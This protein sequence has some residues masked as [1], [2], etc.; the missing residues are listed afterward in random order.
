MMGDQPR[1]KAIVIG[2]GFGGAV[3]ACRLAQAGFEVDLLERGRRYGLA[4]FP[5][6]PRDG[7]VL[8]E[9]RRWTWG[10]SY[11]LWDVRNLEGLTVVQTAGY[12]GGSLGYANVHL[13]AP[14]DV[15]QEGW[16]DDCRGT[17][18]SLLPPMPPKEYAPKRG[19]DEF[20]DLVGYTLDVKP[21]P[22]EW[23]KGGKTLAM[24]NAFR[25]ATNGT[26]QNVFHPPLAIRYP[27]KPERTCG[28]PPTPTP[29]HKLD[30]N[31]HGKPQGACVQCGGCCFGCRY[32][33]KN[34]L[35][36]NYLAK[37]EQSDKVQVRTL[38]EVRTISRLADGR[39]KVHYI[40]H[41]TE[42]AG[43]LEAPYVF[44]CAGSV[45]S[46]ELLL[47]SINEKGLSF[48]QPRPHSDDPYPGRNYFFNADAPAMVF[49]AAT[50]T[51]PT[52]GPVISTALI[53]E[54]RDC[55][56]RANPTAPGRHWFLIEDGGYPASAENLFSLFQTPLLLERNRF[57]PSRR[58]HAP[59]TASPFLQ[60]STRPD[61][62]PAFLAGMMA[63]LR[64]E[65]LPNVL[66]PGFERAARV[67][68]RLGGRLRDGELIQLTGAVLDAMVLQSGIFRAL[69]RLRVDR[70]AR[71]FWKL[72][73]RVAVAIGGMRGDRLLKTTRRIT[74]HR[75]GVDQPKTFPTR[76]G[77][78][79]MGEPYPVNPPDDPFDRR[80][81]VPPPPPGSKALLLAMGRDDLPA[82][83][84]FVGD[85]IVAKFDDAGFPTLTEEERLMRGIADSLQGTLRASPL[86][87]LARRPLSAHSHGG[88]TLG[89]VT[90]DWGEV[91]HNKNLF[92]NDG[93]LL[94]R[95][96]GVNPSA[97]IAALAERNIEHFVRDKLGLAPAAPVPWQREKV[98]AAKWAADRLDERV[99]LMPPKADRI[100]PK[101]GP[102]GFSFREVMKGH[103]SPIDPA[104][105][106]S[107]RSFLPADPKLRVP[108]ARFLN[109]EQAGRDGPRAEFDL[110]ARVLDIGSFLNDRH[111]AMRVTGELKLRLPPDGQLQTVKI[112][113]GIV[114]LF[115][116]AGPDRRLMRYTLPFEHPNGRRWTLTGVKEIEDDRGFDAWLD[117]AVLYTEL[118]DDKDQP[119]ARGV[120]R[121]GIR[122]FLHNQF[123]GLRSE[124]T[125]DPARVI[126][127]LGS[128]AVFFF[129]DLQ[130]IYAPE[131]ERFRGLFGSGWRALPA[132]A[133][134]ATP[135][136]SQLLR[137]L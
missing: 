53:Y 124:G 18:L 72:S 128:F 17:S 32:G 117:T 27:A 41:L 73:Y 84:E 13:R 47:R 3:T 23:R 122:D 1:F 126:W 76:V 10:G 79:L 68:L 40:D 130:G 64:E 35:D 61:R 50:K 14:S 93:A 16:P 119:V 125:R 106:A 12:G 78:A 110:R 29:E 48:P 70:W 116:D 52:A 38:I 43:E 60:T 65:A 109:P 129:G 42:T 85:G 19:L 71:W 100:D 36:R 111:H 82:T 63:A 114:N 62:Y 120:L 28:P 103:L 133:K 121:L 99:D 105:G 80:R 44:L 94:P 51:S 11:G 87:T 22:D 15:F 59:L 69:K 97:T 107:T 54:N 33:A 67:L 34:T 49:D 131:I 6:M 66:P 123:K 77:R 92:V 37:A 30:V 24:A 101:H 39:Y 58:A 7:E 104:D 2:T 8:P 102:I 56:R 86:W 137:G 113:A 90:D 134:H 115:T 31:D 75:Y 98:A 95:P 55:A 21:V 136:T 83:L 91:R 9:P 127:T 96:V 26:P 46:T 135:E 118:H 57:D 5:A 45:S 108:L 112:N 89:K 74:R 4:D 81:P 20:Y 132:E 25:D 88:C